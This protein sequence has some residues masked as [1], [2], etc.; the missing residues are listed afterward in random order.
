M[1]PVYDL[2]PTRAM[3]AAIAL[4]TAVI[5]GPA[6]VHNAVVDAAPSGPPADPDDTCTIVVFAIDQSD[7]TLVNEPKAQSVTLAISC[8]VRVPGSEAGQTRLE[9]QPKW[10]VID[11]EEATILVEAAEDLLE[12]DGGAAGS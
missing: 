11:I 7:A 8:G 2:S 3:F 9:Q 4:G 10:I 1:K 6:L 12:D 5:A